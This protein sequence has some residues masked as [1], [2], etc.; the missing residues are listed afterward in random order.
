MTILDRFRLDDYGCVVTG[1]GRGIGRGIALALAEAGAHVVVTARRVAD[2]ESVA[3][4][5]RERGRKAVA[6]AGDIRDGL[7]DQLGDAAV[8]AFGGL[9]LWVNNA[10]GSDEKRTFPLM[11]TTDEIFRSQLE[12]NLVSAFQGSKAAAARMGEGGCIVN[13]ASGAGMRAAPN[14]GPY[15]AAKAGLLNLTQTMAAELA[16]RRI[17]VNAISPGM[18][19]TDTFMEVLH[20]TEDKLPGLAAAVPLGRLGTPEDIAAAV[21]YLA[22]TAGSW[23]TGQ[24]LFIS[25]GREGGRSA[26]HH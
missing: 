18:V 1:S 15:G 23:M 21:V 14:T 17:R 7:S 11:D 12:L 20:Y 24:N 8:D 6:I 4:E 16:P 3:A 19:P 5:I 2:I 13:I 10:G 22:S 26:E 9:H 25:G